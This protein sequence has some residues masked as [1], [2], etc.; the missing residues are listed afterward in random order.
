M[1]SS[2]CSAPASPGLPGS[3][4]ACAVLCSLHLKLPLPRTSQREMLH[5]IQVYNQLSQSLIILPKYTPLSYSSSCFIISSAFLHD[6]LHLAFISLQIFTHLFVFMLFYISPADISISLGQ[7]K[8][9]FSVLKE[10][11]TYNKHDINTCE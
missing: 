1:L 10:C 11:L 7:G 5:F 2:T 4:W 8:Y 9:L 3:F 6:T